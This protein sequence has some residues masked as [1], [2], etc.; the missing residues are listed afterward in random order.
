[1]N[2]SCRR[3]VGQNFRANH[4]SWYRRLPPSRSP[5]RLTAPERLSSANSI[6]FLYESVLYP[7]EETYSK[8]QGDRS[9]M[10]CKNDGRRSE[11]FLSG[12][13]R[14][15]PISVAR[16][17]LPSLHGAGFYYLKIQDMG[18]IV[19]ASHEIKIWKS[20]GQLFLDYGYIVPKIVSE[21]NNAHR[22]IIG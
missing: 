6:I 12:L 4:G 15:D 18:L 20:S 21:I 5:R 2:S 10:H 1:V 13:W 22:C 16:L 19:H 14:K 3:E 9:S 11:A 17:F 8:S 7:L